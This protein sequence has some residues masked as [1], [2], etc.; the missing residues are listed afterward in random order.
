MLQVAGVTCASK[1]AL[2]SASVVSPNAIHNSSSV[3]SAVMP[4]AVFKNS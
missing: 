4:M 1:S 2:N 3:A